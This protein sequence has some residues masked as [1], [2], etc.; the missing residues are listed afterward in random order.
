M[1]KSLRQQ[2]TDILRRELDCWLEVEQVIPVS[3]YYKAADV[4]RWEALTWRNEKHSI[5]V[6][7]WQTMRQF[8]KEAKNGIVVTRLNGDEVT[9]PETCTGI[10]EI[11]GREEKA[12]ANHG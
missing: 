4:Y 9:N 11:S 6:G 3:G 7:C 5:Q 2:V 10:I 1:P 8:V 12:V